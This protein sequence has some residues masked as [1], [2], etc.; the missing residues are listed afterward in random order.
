MDSLLYD[1]KW[2]CCVVIND[3]VI[4]TKN[5]N[6]NNFFLLK[7]IYET[8]VSK[9]Q[10]SV[11]SSFSAFIDRTNYIT[12]HDF[13]KIL[14]QG[15][16]VDL[17]SANVNL[18]EF[19]EMFFKTEISDCTNLKQIVSTLSQKIDIQIMLSKSL[20]IAMQTILQTEN[21]V[22]WEVF[23]LYSN[24][25]E[26]WG[27]GLSLEAIENALGK[28]DSKKIKTQTILNKLKENEEKVFSFERFN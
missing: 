26:G 9:N 22:N 15:I 17:V 11:V 25:E 12:K 4:N 21:F 2:N 18:D 5:Q 19:F 10:S 6:L 24:Y 13:F 23:R 27:D 1:A 8:I 14:E 7:D 20:V 28:I 3:K 16:K